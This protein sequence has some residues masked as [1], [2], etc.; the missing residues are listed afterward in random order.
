MSVLSSILYFA[1]LLLAAFGLMAIVTTFGTTPRIGGIALLLGI[2]L[3]VGGAVLFIRLRQRSVH[4]RWWQR[5]VGVLAAALVAFVALVIEVLVSPSPLLTNYFT[6]C[7]I[8]LFGLVCTII[9]VW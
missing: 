3:V 8:F 9:A 6:A 7:I 2:A 1:S 5:L 4:L